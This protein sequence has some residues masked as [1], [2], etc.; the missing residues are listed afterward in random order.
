MKI[1][2]YLLS[3]CIMST[4]LCC[5][6]GCSEDDPDGQSQSSTNATDDQDQSG[7]PSPDQP[8]VSNPVTGLCDRYNTKWK[9]YYSNGRMSGGTDND[10][11]I[12]KF[13][14]N[15]FTITET[16][17]DE[18]GY[19]K[20][21]YSNIQLN[22][23]GYITNA[24]FV[25]EGSETYAGNTE[26]WKYTG[27]ISISYQN[28]EYISK[29]IMN[30]QVEENGESAGTENGEFTF[31]WNEGNLISVNSKYLDT[32]D[33]EESYNEGSSL[34][35]FNYNSGQLNNSGIYLSDFTGDITEHYFWYAGLLGKPSKQIPVHVSTIEEYN[36][37]YQYTENYTITANYNGD[38]TVSG[39]ILR[40]EQYGYESNISFFYGGAYPDFDNGDLYKLNRTTKKSFIKRRL[41][42]NK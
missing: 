30:A 40:N 6:T 9:F 18:S 22:K 29:I 35:T 38:A 27:S 5:F 1:L 32:N 2:N 37:G 24:N 3:A 21:V 34:I 7:T 28:D 10:G 41:A 39:L 25:Y 23:N 4:A 26:T 36:N 17:E 16:W 31:T 15:P 12:F 8:I 42:R 13:T 20:E 19:D 33:E 11:D 14:S